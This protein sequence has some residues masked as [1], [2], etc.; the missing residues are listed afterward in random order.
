MTKKFR[1][2][3]WPKDT[4]QRIQDARTLGATWQVIADGFGC[5]LATIRNKAIELGLLEPKLVRRFTAEDD[6]IL[7]ADYLANADLEETAKKIGCS[8]GVLRQRIYNNHKDLLNTVRT[9]HGTKQLKRYGLGLLAHGATAD[10]AAKNLKSKIIAAKAAA[11][12]AAISAKE[13]RS[14]QIIETMLAD[15]AGGKDRNVAIFEARAM[16]V[17]LQRIADNFDITRE[18]IRQICDAE[19]FRAAID[20]NL[21]HEAPPV[22]QRDI[23]YVGSGSC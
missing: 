6:A 2:S 18:R 4:A 14:N 5:S 8:Y 1:R 9:S 10:E 15:I 23:L 13:R 21:S 16:G 11:R 3:V 7:R 20:A 17:S 22:V 19:A 12:V